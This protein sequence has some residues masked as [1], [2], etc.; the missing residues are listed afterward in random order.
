MPFQLSPGVI[1]TERDLTT[2]VPAVATT[3]GA[4][5]GPFKWGPVLERVL[6]ETENVLVS[7]F[8][9]PD[10][11]TAT[12]FFTASNFLAYGNNLTL[13][14]VVGDEA[15]NA[16][17]DDQQT[18]ETFDGDGVEDT[19]TTTETFSPFP[20]SANLRVIVD[21][22]LQVEGASNDYEFADAGGGEVEVTF[23]AGSEPGLG[24][25]NVVIEVFA[26][27]IDNEDDFES[28]TDFAASMYGKYPG[29][30][31]NGLE[32]WAIDST[33]WASLSADEQNNFTSAPTGD[34]IHILVL[35]ELGVF[36]GVAGT[37]LEKFEFL[38]TTEGTLKDDGSVAYYV[39]R[40]NQSSRYVWA[41]DN[42]LA[43]FVDGKATLGGGRDDNTVT[44]GDR[45]EGYDLFKNADI[46]DVSLLLAGEASGTLISYLIQN[47]AEFR[48][49]CVVFCS[50]EREDVVNNP[51]QEVDDAIEFRET[52]PSSSY[53]FMDNT[54]KYQFDRYNDI[55]RW[56]PANG[57]TAGTVVFTDRQTDPWF[58]PGGFNRGQIRNVTKLAYNPTQ[59][60]RDRLYQNGINP[61]V[62]FTGEGTVLFGDKTMLSKPS[63]FDRIN[64]R[65]L[66]I[67][68]EKAIARAAK[69]TLF[70]F[71]DEFTRAQFVALV[72]PF[73]EDVRGR[74]G[75]TDF[76]VVADET[77]NT[78]EVIDRNEFVGDIYIKPNRSIN[79]IQLNFIAVR[80]NV[81]FSEIAGA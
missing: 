22:V 5:C 80:T 73:L 3:A 58:S 10:N 28:Q 27:Q 49:D 13:V 52:L 40:L 46:V 68:L 24:T 51:G 71:N 45:I 62:S 30:S 50:P 37:V 61:I 42:S 36:T 79:F 33:S 72:Q 69:Y 32:V 74:R 15:V 76:R 2:I 20:D 44:D 7:E 16:S 67:V 23:N 48:R 18:I 11:D 43:D 66:F 39:E 17:T 41:V 64:V 8:G 55:F 54:W 56:I 75:L 60:E 53:G 63:A 19:F 57:S 12:S 14:R 77:N 59:P 47:I 65:R 4:F 6:V 1:T 29:I 25:D 9:R 34:E 35:D 31:A 26:R 21:G 81:N 38:S 78:P 70:E